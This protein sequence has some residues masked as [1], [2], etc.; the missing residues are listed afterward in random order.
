MSHILIVDDEPHLRA[1][2]RR[3]LEGEGH[4]V[5]EAENGLKALNLWEEHSI[6]LIITDIYMPEKDGIELLRAIRRAQPGAKIISM[7]GASERGLL[8]LN[9]A[10]EL[11]GADR[12]LTKPFNRAG[13][14]EAVNACAKA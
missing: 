7:T 10:A 6:D 2:I 5:L 3:M 1:V 8:D 13:L 14:L 11:L 4:V 9:E 12:A